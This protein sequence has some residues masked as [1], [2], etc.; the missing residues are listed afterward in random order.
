MKLLQDLIRLTENKDDLSLLPKDVMN[1]IKKNIRKGAENLEQ[2]WANALE[3][4]HKA[5]DVEGV[6]RPDPTMESAWK[7]YEENLQYAVQQLASNRGMDDDWRMSSSMFHEAL[8]GQ[9]KFQITLQNLG[10]KSQY[11]V[12]A[13]SIADVVNH[14]NEGVSDLDV[15][16][17]NQTSDEA[18][19]RFSKWGIR[20]N[21]RIDVERIS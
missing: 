4:V 1:A 3:L 12:E 6:Q 21:L 16:V 10:D 15:N 9:N 8:K 17:L 2:K 11:V 20:R 7:Q 18:R 19:I 13:S 14:I 5:Y